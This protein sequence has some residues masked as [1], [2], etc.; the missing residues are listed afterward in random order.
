MEV[1]QE[2]SSEIRA[3]LGRESHSPDEIV[4]EAATAVFGSPL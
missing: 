3:A 1:S 2:G 4:G